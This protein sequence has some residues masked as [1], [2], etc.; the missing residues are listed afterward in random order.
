MFSLQP[1]RGVPRRSAIDFRSPITANQAWEYSV[2]QLREI[3]SC[4]SL[5]NLKW[6]HDLVLSKSVLE[7]MPES[8]I[9]LIHRGALDCNYETLLNLNEMERDRLD[10]KRT[11][12]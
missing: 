3:V 1:S 6:T 12:G 4:R 11:A 9:T 10:W 2:P 5:H 7:R 8:T